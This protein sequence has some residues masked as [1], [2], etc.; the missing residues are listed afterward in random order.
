MRRR[1]FFAVFAAAFFLAIRAGWGSPPDPKLWRLLIE[2]K[3][4]RPAV[5]WAIPHAQRTVLAACFVLEGEPVYFSRKDF[6]ELGLDWDRFARQA[7]DN[8]GTDL[9]GLKPKYVRDKKQVIEYAQIKSDRPFAAAAVLAPKF[10]NL[11]EGVFG[12]TVLVA[13]PNRHTVYVFPKLAS[14]YQEYA[15]MILDDYHGALNPV[16]TEV[17]EIGPNG[18]KA[19]GIYEEP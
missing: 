3:F 11:F 4:M 18:M 1:A 5:S 7:R 14:A 16:S 13:I 9:E 10:L 15:P 6:D 12:S 2:P 8:G 19:I 17:F